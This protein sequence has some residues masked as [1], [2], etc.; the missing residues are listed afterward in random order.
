VEQSTE[1]SGHNP[2]F[3]AIHEGMTLTDVERIIGKPGNLTAQSKNISSYDWQD[4]RTF[5]T[6]GVILV[7]GKVDTKSSAGL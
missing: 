7:D 3:L 6:I 4:P 5:G 2:A 1:P